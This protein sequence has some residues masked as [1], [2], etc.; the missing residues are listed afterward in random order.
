MMNDQFE[1]DLKD[2]EDEIKKFIC[3]ECNSKESGEETLI[4]RE[5]SPIKNK[6][7]WSSVM[8]QVECND[9]KM[10]IPTHIAERW[11]NLSIE[12]AKNEWVKVYRKDSKKQKI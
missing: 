10:I 12:Q 3:P 6:N 1:F 8:Q 5:P 4:S 9:C 2:D 7:P 11:D